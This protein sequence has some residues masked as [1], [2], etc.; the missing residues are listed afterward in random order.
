MGAGDPPITTATP[1][2]RGGASRSRAAVTAAVIV[3][4]GIG[5]ALAASRLGPRW[6]E[7]SLPRGQKPAILLVTLDATRA[8]RIGAYGY[9]Q[10]KTPAADELA[11]QG[12][13]FEQAYSAAPLCLPS[14]TAILTGR[15]PVHTGVR[16]E[17]DVLGPDA[18][19][20]AE[21]FRAA[22]YR[23]AAFVGTTSLDQSHGLGRG[24]DV[25]DD[26]FGLPGKRVGAYE[27]GAASA[28]VDRAL[29][30][31]QAPG[32]EPVFLWAHLA[33]SMAPHNAPA[34]LAKDF[35]G[36]AYDAEIASVDAQMARLVAGVR[37]RHPQ[38]LVVAL[39]DHGESLGD[40]GEDTFGYFVYSVTTRVPLLISMPGKVPSGVRVGP[41]TRTVDLAP[42]LLDLL[43]L[44]ALAEADGVS[45][46]PLIVGR[47]TQ[48]PGPAAIENLSVRKKY[49]LAPIFALREGPYLYVKA[50]R[51]EL[52]DTA[53]DPQEKD[54]A[55]ARLTR[56]ATRLASELQDRIPDA[57]HPGGLRDPKDALDLYNRYQLALE[58]EGRREFEQA[59]VAHQSILSEVPGFVYSRRKL[60]ELLIR[61]GRFAESELEMKD[62][63]AKGEALD[64]TYLNLALLRY[65]AKKPD[66]ALDWVSQGETRFP[67]SPALRHRRGRLLLEAKKYAEAEAELREAL[68]LEPRL[69]DAYVARGEALHGQG[70]DEEAKGV[71]EEVRRLAPESPEAGEVIPGLDLTPVS[72]VSPA[73]SASPA[74]SPPPR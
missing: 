44:P 51:P 72:P 66:E 43:G 65:R 9:G 1:L 40:H 62:L 60:S 46:V 34:A 45:L 68:E 61:A 36:R 28:V 63:V 47:V 32:D 16:D 59:I 54:D 6:R 5:A 39:A 57:T 2:A 11:A 70:R 27:R 22:G 14:H 41:V 53:Q 4:T 17:L 20:L 26:D 31:T 15:L 55:S 35:P 49:G 38:T 30:W 37:A 24:F 7:R 33:D 56:V 10:G 42:T 12:V 25:Y 3:A 19:T 21:R 73:A 64:N 50:P 13:L 71:L 18:P 8:D 67:R 74:A 58:T 29:A 52:Y 69:L 48:G 23:T